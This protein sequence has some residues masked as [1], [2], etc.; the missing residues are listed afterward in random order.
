M[1]LL[2]LQE[3]RVKFIKLKKLFITLYF[4]FPYVD[5]FKV[6]EQQIDLL[7]EGSPI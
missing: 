6:N 7:L 5:N 2:G 3:K 4:F 1:F